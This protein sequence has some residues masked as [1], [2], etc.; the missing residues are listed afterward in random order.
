MRYSCDVFFVCVLLLNDFIQC[1]RTMHAHREQTRGV[2]LG[3]RLD[4]C[5]RSIDSGIPS[6]DSVLV[7]STCVEHNAFIL[8]FILIQ[9]YTFDARV[10]YNAKCLKS[11]YRVNRS[12][13]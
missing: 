1:M 6:P 12:S 5:K 7:F 8:A 3:T 13:L 10:R 2:R 9:C 11:V 4:S